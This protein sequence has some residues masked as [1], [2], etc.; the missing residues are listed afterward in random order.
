MSNSV[1]DEIAKERMRQIQSEGWTEAHDDKHFDESLA[2]AA[3][4]YALPEKMRKIEPAHWT[5]AARYDDSQ[6]V[7]ARWKL[8]PWRWDFS[9]WKPSDRRRDLIKAAALIVAEIERMDRMTA[10]ALKENEG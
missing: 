4:C 7:E 6:W 1:I 9:W 8:W 2:Q 5:G 10:P 3:A